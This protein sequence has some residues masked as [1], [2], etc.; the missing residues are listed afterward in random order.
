MFLF[1]ITSIIFPLIWDFLIGLSIV[2]RYLPSVFNQNSLFLI[3]NIANLN[4]DGVWILYLYVMIAISHQVWHLLV[5]LTKTH[6][7]LGNWFW[8]DK[9]LQENSFF[10]FLVCFT[11]LK[12]FSDNSPYQNPYSLICT[13][14]WN[15]GWLLIVLK[16]YSST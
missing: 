7:Y 16:I 12:V 15:C 14:T 1:Q 3:Y 8:G 2:Q 9:Q 10:F 5:K 6:L 11:L 13:H 4:V